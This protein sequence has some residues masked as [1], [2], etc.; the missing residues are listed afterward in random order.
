MPITGRDRLDLARLL[1]EFGADKN[2]KNTD[3]F[4]AIDLAVS[5]PMKI[6]LQSKIS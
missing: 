5:T 4:T 6:L 1:I 2:L 3:N